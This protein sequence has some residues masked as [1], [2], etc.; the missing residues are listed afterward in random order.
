MQQLRQRL[1]LGLEPVRAALGFGERSARA[2]ERLAGG[3]MGGLGAHGGRFRR[4]GRGLRRFGGGGERSCIGVPCAVGFDLLELGFDGRDLLRQAAEP[5][6]VLARGIFQRVASRGQ[7]GEGAGEFVGGFFRACE[8][9]VGLRDALVD[10]RAL[11]FVRPDLLLQRALFGGKPRERGLRVGG[12][13]PLTLDV[14]PELNEAAVELGHAV[15]GARLLVIER[16]PRH[17]QPLQGGGC[18]RLGLAQRRQVAGRERLELGRLGLRAGAL[19]DHAHGGILGLLGLGELGIGGDPA[20]VKQRRLGLAHL[21]GDGAV[22]DRLPRLPFER[23]DLA[24]ELRDDVFQP[25]EVLL[26]PAQP[27]LGLV[28]PR[29]QARDAGR[30]LEHAPALLRLGLDDLADAP[31]MHHRGRTRAGGGVGEQDV[32]VARAHL[33]AV[34]AVERPGIALDP[35]RDVERLVLVEL[36]GRLAR[37]VVDL[38]RHLGIVASRPVVGAG[39]DHVVHVGGAQRLVRGLA[40]HPAQRFHQVGFA[41]AVGPDHAGEPRLDQEI[42]RLDE[43]FEAEQA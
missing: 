33:A 21:L 30:L 25:G 40:H 20:Q 10:A 3:G 14:V 13:A 11:G 4:R 9:R 24:G 5:I 36:G 31:L 27:Q 7:V 38:D 28:P 2:V 37:A 43:G 26:R 41:A 34:D 12:K 35:A 1:G 8:H 22:A 6:A 19:G 23:V 16:L 17:H 39:K 32:H 18:P 42:G 29:V 15:L